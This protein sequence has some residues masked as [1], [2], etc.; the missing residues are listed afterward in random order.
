[1][2]QK[3]ILT[4]VQQNKQI[5]VHTRRTRLYSELLKHLCLTLS[6]SKKTQQKKT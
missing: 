6:I 5:L 1:M 2:I 4:I 3:V